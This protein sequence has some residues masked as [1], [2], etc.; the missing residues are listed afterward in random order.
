MPGKLIEVWQANAGG[1][2]RHKKDGYAAPLDP[3][4]GGCGRCI[5]GEDG[6]YSFR[7]IQQSIALKQYRFPQL[8][9][10]DY[11][12]STLCTWLLFFSVKLNMKQHHHGLHSS[13]PFLLPSLQDKLLRGSEH[14]HT[15]QSN[16]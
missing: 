7:T 3:N 10:P 14:V 12:L 8:L 15:H 13:H 5:S 4:F 1:R 2:Y 9:A 6:S 16:E 11:L